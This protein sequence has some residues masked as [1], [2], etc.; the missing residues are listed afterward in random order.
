MT[1]LAHPSEAF[2]NFP[3]QRTGLK[4]I[5]ICAEVSVGPEWT[6]ASLGT[7]TTSGFCARIRRKVD[8]NLPI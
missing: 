3:L 8:F 2:Q 6:D 5:Q 4:K 1:Y 7:S